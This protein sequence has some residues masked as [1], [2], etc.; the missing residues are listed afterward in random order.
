VDNLFRI[1]YFN[2]KLVT[3]TLSPTKIYRVVSGQGKPGN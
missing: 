3:S 1:N 2:N